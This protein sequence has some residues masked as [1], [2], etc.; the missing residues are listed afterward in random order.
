L[1][2]A[3]ADLLPASIVW[4]PGRGRAAAGPRPARR[5]Q[6]RALLDDPAQPLHPLLDHARIGAALAQPTSQPQGWHNRVAYLLEVNA[7]LAEHR[8]TVT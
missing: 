4:R 7:W 1:R 5:V 3:V 6:L 8:I 2:H